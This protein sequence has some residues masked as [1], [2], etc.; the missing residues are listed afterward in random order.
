MIGLF[1]WSWPT[2][3]IHSKLRLYFYLF[4]NKMLT[5]H[6]ELSIRIS[7]LKVYRGCEVALNVELNKI[8]FL[9]K[10]TLKNYL[11]KFYISKHIFSFINSFL[12]H[13]VALGCCSFFSLV[14]FMNVSLRLN[15]IIITF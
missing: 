3:I 10:N 15:E 11:N 4:G 12:Q 8:L 13:W 9:Y 6:Q 7:L 2:M 14:K 5:P 1:C